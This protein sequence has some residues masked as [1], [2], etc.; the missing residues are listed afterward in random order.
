MTSSKAT[1][2]SHIG[3]DELGLEKPLVHS[4][5]FRGHARCGK[6]LLKRATTVVSAERRYTLCRPD[7]LF[8]AI[9]NKPCPPVLN[10]FGN[11]PMAIGD[12]RRPAGHGLDY[13][14]AEG[15]RPIN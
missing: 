9:D 7:G 6:T 2:L 13:H 10:H 14:Q 15:F 1:S 11:G 5:I 12:N 4:N 3:R 8:S